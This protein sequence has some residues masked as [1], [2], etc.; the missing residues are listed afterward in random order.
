MKIRSGFVSNSSSSSFILT[1]EENCKEIT[2]AQLIADIA[3]GDFD[4]RRYLIKGRDVWQELE[5]FRLSYGMYNLIKA[6]PE[7]FIQYGIPRIETIYK[8]GWMF[9]R[10]NRGWDLHDGSGGWGSQERLKDN[11]SCIILDDEAIGVST[12]KDANDEFFLK[13]MVSDDEWEMLTDTDDDFHDKRTILAYCNKFRVQDF[14]FSTAT[15]NTYIGINED[16]G[17]VLNSST[18]TY[19]KLSK[20]DIEI[21]KKDP[22]KLKEGCMIYDNIMVLK[23]DKDY[24]D[25]EGHSWRFRVLEGLVLKSKDFGVFV[26]ENSEGENPD[27]DEIVKKHMTILGSEYGLRNPESA[28]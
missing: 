27:V 28:I 25:F 7:R 8:D 12:W 3:E 15:T 20:S 5:V 17:T 9:N 24:Y 2:G 6:F 16:A 4:F 23:E 26:K 10:D 14:D 19:K 1:K 13:Y 11:E 22:S 18:F 21:I